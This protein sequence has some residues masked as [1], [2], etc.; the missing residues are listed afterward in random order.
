MLK[1]GSVGC[2]SSTRVSFSPEPDGKFNVTVAG[3]PSVVPF[4]DPAVCCSFL[5]LY[6]NVYVPGPFD[7]VAWNEPSGLSFS[8][9]PA[10]TF[11]KVVKS[12]LS[13]RPL[14]STSFSRTPGELME[15]YCALVA[16]KL[17]LF[18]M[19]ALPITQPAPLAFWSH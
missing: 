3:V 15:R 9:K 13:G 1:L 7:A 6:W 12:T 17:S 18:T 8:V 10:D 4:R 11:C 2:L 5:T 16:A 19:G 14:G